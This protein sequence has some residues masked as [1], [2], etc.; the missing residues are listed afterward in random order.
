MERRACE[1][2][3][4]ALF[5]SGGTLNS[6]FAS[7]PGGDAQTSMGGSPRCHYGN[8]QLMEVVVT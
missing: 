1:F 8:A 5:S 7:L 3:Y 4:V 6:T 2:T